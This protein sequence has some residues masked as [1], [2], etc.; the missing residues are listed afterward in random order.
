MLSEEKRRV[1][2]LYAEGRKLYKLSRFAEARERFAAALAVDASDGPSRVYLE[3]CEHYSVE[4]PDEDW[5]GVYV[6][7]HK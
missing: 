4:P 3:R 1:L 5:D 6:M 2:E 7:K